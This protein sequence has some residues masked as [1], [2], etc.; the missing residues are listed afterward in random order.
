MFQVDK[1]VFLLIPGEHRERIL[2]Q[3]RVLEST[4]E[5]IVAEFADPITLPAG[6][7]V[8]LYADFRGKF[9]QHGASVIAFQQSRPSIYAFKKVGEPVSAESRGSY[10]VSTVTLE[11]TARIAMEAC[12]KIVDISPEGFAAITAQDY[13]IGSVVDSTL[14]CEGLSCAGPA[15]VQTLK[16]LPNGNRRYGF[17]AVDKKGSAMRKVLGQITATVQRLQLRRLSRTG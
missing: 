13:P 16:V 11:I 17:L 15:R 10:R 4:A 7:D 1:A 6:T 12:C 8:N 9:Y 3:G 5:S 14:V 2:H